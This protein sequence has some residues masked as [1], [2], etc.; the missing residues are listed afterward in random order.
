ME[1]TGDVVTRPVRS[2]H[3][4]G[5]RAREITLLIAG[6][7]DGEG[8]K[9]ATARRGGLLFATFVE[10]WP[11]ALDAHQAAQLSRLAMA[12]VGPTSGAG[13]TRKP[14]VAKIPVRVHIEG[15]QAKR[16]MNAVSVSGLT[17]VL[18][19]AGGIFS[20]ALASRSTEVAFTIESVQAIHSH[21]GVE[22]GRETSALTARHSR[23]CRIDLFYVNRSGDAGG[24]AWVPRT[25]AFVN[26][27]GD[28]GG[29]RDTRRHG[30]TLA[31][32]FGHLFGLGHA[33][34][35]TR[36]MHTAADGETLTEREVG[37]LASYLGEWLSDCSRVR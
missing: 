2:S 33:E 32:E 18:D 28:G 34:D 1:E 8:A 36:L 23:D 31:H 16:L 9:G 26:A 14:V 10:G 15:G 19:R 24:W 12:R 5:E 13:E 7:E 29:L 37:L 21:P 6:D 3:G 17:S 22:F 25:S 20:D 30:R 4:P 27:R 11:D 35:A